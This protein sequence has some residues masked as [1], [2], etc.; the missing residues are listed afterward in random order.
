MFILIILKERVLPVIHFQEGPS[1]F[2]VM[3]Y[4][5]LGNLED[6]DKEGPIAI[7]EATEVL[8]QALEALAY[9]HPRGVAHRDLKPENILLESRLP[10]KIK[11]ADFGLANDKS[12][13]KTMCGTRLYAA[14]EIVSNCNYTQSVDLW[15][16]G[17]I[18]LQY[19]YDL[20]QAANFTRR[21]HGN[22]NSMK[23]LILTWCQRIVDYVNSW[24]S[25]G[26]IDLLK[27]GMLRI[28]PKERLSATECLNKGRDLGIFYYNISD[29]GSATPTRETAIQSGVSSHDGSSTM[30]LGLLWGTEANS[31]GHNS[32]I[33]C[34]QLE[35]S[36]IFKP[37]DQVPRTSTDDNHNHLQI[38]GFRTSFG[39]V[40]PEV[41]ADMDSHLSSN[42]ST[43][44]MGCKRQRSPAM[45]SPIWPSDKS[46]VK[47]QRD[48]L[49]ENSPVR[50]FTH[51][52]ISLQN[53]VM[54][55][56]NTAQCKTLF[57]HCY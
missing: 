10:I 52:R 47:R 37:S 40:W 28:N 35:Q 18:A 1:P 49:L 32:K 36:S 22:E 56:I 42:P 8:L 19:V 39:Q 41:K 57:L 31:N 24:E 29:L 51:F 2:F 38:S 6:S 46:S 25:E 48:V 27:T 17:V 44:L 30:I 26:L 12:E 15:S 43:F 13:L 55:L 5:P 16:L 54:K 9:L 11:L 3:P 21:K 20:P 7:E 33:G 34:S 45:S 4:L 53:T 50:A 14:P 23:A